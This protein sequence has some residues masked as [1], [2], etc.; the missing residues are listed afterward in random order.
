MNKT[1]Q[2]FIAMALLSSAFLLWSHPVF[3]FQDE[4]EPAVAKQK[5]DESVEDHQ[6]RILNSYSQ[7]EQKLLALR[8]FEKENNPA[9]SKLLQRAYELSQEQGTTDELERI[10]A[11]L[12]TGELRDAESNQKLVLAD[13]KRLLTLLQSEDR[14]KR[15]QDELKRNQE[16]LKEVERL[17]RI[18]K[19]LRGEAEGKGDAPRISKSQKQAAERAKQLAKKIRDNEERSREKDPA[20]R[21]REDSDSKK[22]KKGNGKE[23]KG[24]EKGK[25]EGEGKGEKSGE[26]KDGK[27]T[28][29]SGKGKPGKGQ[30]GEGQPSDGEPSDGEPSENQPS[31]E[32]MNPVRRRVAAA[33]R[34]MREA[35]KKLDQAK[36]DESVKDMN[37]AI[38]ELEAAKK[39]LEEIL[40]QLREEEVERSLSMLESRFRLMM[41]R[42]IKVR[43]KTIGLNA[44]PSEQRLADFEINAGKLSAEQ[45]SIAT[46][47]SRALLLLREDGSSVAF[48]QTVE[49][50][51]VDMEQVGSR[52]AGSKVGEMTIEIEND[53]IETLGNLIEALAQ[54][55][56]ENEANRN[57]RQG[58]P[59]GSGR[60]GE[61]SLV[62]QI[63]EIRML[64][65]LQ[66][67]IYRR[68]TRYAKMLDDPNDQIGQ[69]TDPEI[70]AA[71]RRLTAKQKQLTEI[72]KEIVES[73]DE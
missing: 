60:P 37:E 36:R 53:I 18:Q 71:L 44:V 68:H 15:I 30:P 52:L 6:T 59:G 31:D 17:L 66:D 3:A 51:K 24:K 43:D 26:P 61:S 25:G 40:R 32:E 19:S 42:E 16:Y 73:I 57:R 63:A 13:M 38:R 50:M 46:E 29:K 48:P 14:G 70:R 41:E 33:E 49:E 1:K 64:K 47:A 67:R 72:T 22:G 65:A 55:Q 10:V 8:E 7:L 2:R 9:R 21:D 11:L 39:E 56:K 69:T 58:Q 23:G 27:P 35:K 4:Q 5:K 62:G 54:A 20:D 28:G 12:T 34:R 45:S